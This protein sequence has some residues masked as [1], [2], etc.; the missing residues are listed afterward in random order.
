MRYRV[1][2]ILSP[3]KKDMKKRKGYI[4]I[5]LDMQDTVINLWS[6]D[7]YLY[8]IPRKRITPKLIGML[9]KPLYSSTLEKEYLDYLTNSSLVTKEYELLP[10][11]S[12]K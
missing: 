12:R 2:Y 4:L 7:A 5:V 6:T 3:E 8:T 1:Y 10:H 11:N 9:T